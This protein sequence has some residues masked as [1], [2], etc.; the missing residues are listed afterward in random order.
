MSA[1]AD[2]VGGV[3]PG[4]DSPSRIGQK[5]TP[6]ARRK[7]RALERRYQETEDQMELLQEHNAVVAEG[8]KE[9]YQL[10]RTEDETVV[11][12]AI[13]ATFNM[14]VAAAVTLI[15][16]IYVFSQISSTMP[17]P[18][19]NDLANASDTVKSTTGDAFALGAVAII[20]LVAVLILGLIGSGF[21]NGGGGSRVRR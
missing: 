8:L 9:Q 2:T 3:L 5:L 4:P 10:E 14:V 13:S 6:A 19:N 17:K 12:A 20:V 18:E 15:I 1:T 21:G 7:A 11:D 16:G